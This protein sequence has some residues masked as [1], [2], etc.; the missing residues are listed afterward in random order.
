MTRKAPPQIEPPHYENADVGAIQALARGDASPEAQRRALDWIINAAS[1]TYDQSFHPD[2]A[3]LT[4]FA[5]GRR[6]VG[7]QIVKLT[8]LNLSKLQRA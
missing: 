5:E 3:R 1:A 7:N 4:D 8:K 6:F 2:N